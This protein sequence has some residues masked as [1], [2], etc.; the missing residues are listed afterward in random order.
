MSLT[1]I[2]TV[3]PYAPFIDEVVKHPIVSGLRLNTVMP[4]KEGKLEETVKRLRDQA[5]D[6]DLYIDLKCRQL[7][8][9]TFGVPP[10]T[11]IELTHSISVETPVTAY[12]SDG[13]EYATVLEVEGN[14]LFMQEGPKRVVGPGESINIPH[15]SLKIAG[16]LTE[17]DKEYIKAGS[18]AGVHKYML[19][20]FEQQ[21]DE[22]ELLLL[23]PKAE[24]IYK[25]ESP[26]GLQY[27]KK[28]FSGKGR[29]MA[30]RGDLYVELPKPHQIIEAMETIVQK[31]ANAIAA[32]RILTSF[33]KSYMPSCQDISD[34]D[35][36]M[37]MGYRTLMLGD[38]VCM[39]RES[40]LSA[41][42]LLDGMAENYWKRGYFK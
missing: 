30:G 1:A 41:L 12:F 25:I 29:L 32:S 10:F 17:K 5:R 26:R 7:R 23:D 39:K 37:R 27:V 19:S 15:P 8:V 4:I 2:V 28:N 33:S 3:P 31:D 6:K 16:Y 35:S 11:K 36:L 20:F 22:K 14:T 40:V 34:V 13:E 21:E 24:P 18:A 38:D 9:K 42:N